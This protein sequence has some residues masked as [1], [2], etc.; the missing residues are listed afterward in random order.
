MDHKNRANHLAVSV[1]Y[2][3]VEPAGDREHF[4]DLARRRNERRF[5]QRRIDRAR[6]DFL[7]KVD[8]TS[9]KHRRWFRIV[10]IEPDPAKRPELAELWRAS[11]YSG[12]LVMHGKSQVL[13][14][15]AS[16]LLD[17][18][19]LSPDLARGEH[20]HDIIDDLWM[21]APRWLQWFEQA[22]LNAP[23]WLSSIG[24]V[25]RKTTKAKVG[26][27]PGWDWEDIGLFVQ[28]TL[29]ERGDFEKPENA[30]AGWRGKSDLYRLIQ[31]Y[32]EVASMAGLEA[33][34]VLA[35]SRNLF[36]R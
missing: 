15:S 29:D 24:A 34:Q 25:K 19:R 13:C 27:K 36:R 22:G 10:D 33:H 31:G 28:K 21:T 4:E 12:D 5:G 14:L 35:G 26:T 18:H 20:F 17:D 23:T 11:I 8:R 6:S 2:G 7:E 3:F 30:T 1:W 16:P 32:V 9:R